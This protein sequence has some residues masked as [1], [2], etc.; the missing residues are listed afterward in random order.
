MII[1]RSQ[2]PAQRIPLSQSQTPH[3]QIVIVGGGPRGLYCLESLIRAFSRYPVSRNVNVHIFDPS[4]HPG[5]GNVYAL[6]QPEYLR[7]NFPN[8]RIDAWI[9]R[10]S[11]EVDRP[12]LLQW[13][14]E[15]VPHLANAE[16]FCP[17]PIVGRYLHDCFRRVLDMTP[18]GVAVKVHRAKVTEVVKVGSRWKISTEKDFTLADDLILTLGHEGWRSSNTLNKQP[19][20][21]V[22][23]RVFPVDSQLSLDRIPPKSSIAVKGFGLT[24]I[25]AALALTEGRGG[26]FYEN[27]GRWNYWYSGKEPTKIFPFSRSGRPILAK[28]TD[29]R[30]TLPDCLDDV[31]DSGQSAISELE[32]TGNGAKAV[33]ELWD[34]ITSTAV[35]AFQAVTPRRSTASVRTQLSQ[36]F[37]WWSTTT[38]TST[39]AYDAMKRSRD[40][41]LGLKRPNEAWI[42]GETWRRIYPA[43][44]S[45]VSRGGITDEQWHEFKPI[46]NEMER[47]A[48]GPPPENMS[49]M[50]ALIDARVVD[51][52]FIGGAK[53]SCCPA[54]IG[55]I[56]ADDCRQ[57]VD[58]VINAVIPSPW[59]FSRKGLI[60][61][62][63]D[64]HVLTWSN[65]SIGMPI[66]EH[67]SPLENPCD[68]LAVF[69]RVT[70]GSVLGNDTLSRKL[71][72]QIENWATKTAKR[73]MSPE[74]NP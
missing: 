52:R 5:A 34:T 51:L 3:H 30:M 6:D 41:G 46:T 27:N 45:W 68:N 57:D 21:R 64:S 70:E 38:F 31:W 48:F 54:K 73:I 59:Q 50:L 11:S 55:L 62:L 69:G 10:H 29:S 42:W 4:P 47:L 49:R 28:S 44:V 35:Q 12:T 13:L 63:L 60:A 23:E 33:E 72:P 16:G 18:E 40:I 61:K 22:I 39:Q 36:W 9:D 43:L 37:T 56:G 8:G 20:P 67:G 65:R 32:S 25:D 66:D 14:S 2:I 19:D 26:R 74:L 24:W 17:R 7:M 53:L 71:H 15:H 58:A 1:K